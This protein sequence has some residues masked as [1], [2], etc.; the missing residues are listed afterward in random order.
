MPF[1]HYLKILVEFLNYELASDDF[2]N[3]WQAALMIW[4]LASLIILT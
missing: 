4:N 1:R 2:I 3:Q